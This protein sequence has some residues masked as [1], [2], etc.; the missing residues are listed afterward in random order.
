MTPL[1][2]EKV[3]MKVCMIG[4]NSV[5]KTSLVRRYVF[6]DFDDRY[7]ATLG[8]KV[9]KRMASVKFP[10]LGVEFDIAMLIHDIMG[11]MEFRALLR[12]AYF[13]GAQGLI[14]VCDLTSG[15]TFDSLEEWIESAYGVTGRIPVE[16]LGNKV[17]LEDDLV[18]SEVEIRKLGRNYKAPHKLTS[19]KTGANV[20]PAFEEIA[21]VVAE[22]KLRT[23]LLE[24]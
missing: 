9:T 23:K 4:D 7:L 21:R 20:E 19:A 8:A 10:E 5:G 14:A 3:K 17:D 11:A 13:F 6:D 2:K 18:V 12:E 22:R 16:F 1:R 24:N 15:K